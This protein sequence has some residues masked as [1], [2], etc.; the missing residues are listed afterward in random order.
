MSTKKFL[1]KK[2]TL[3][4][5]D[6]PNHK[7][8]YRWYETEAGNKFCRVDFKPTE[9]LNVKVYLV[10]KLNVIRANIWA[11]EIYEVPRRDLEYPGY[12]NHWKWNGTTAIVYEVKR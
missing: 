10:K 6:H 12:P 7:G 4:W 11:Y 8:P 2:V 3:N 5:K 1:A 9:C